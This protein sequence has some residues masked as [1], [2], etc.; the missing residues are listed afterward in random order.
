[1]DNR[2]PYC[3]QI[4]LLLSLWGVALLLALTQPGVAQAQGN[5]FGSSAP[6]G[7][8]G[9]GPGAPMGS[10]PTFAP[11]GPLQGM[12]FILPVPVIRFMLRVAEAQRRFSED[13]SEKMR[14]VGHGGSWRPAAVIVLL[15]F[16]YGIFHAVGPGHGKFVTGTYFMVRRARIVHGVLMG[17]VIAGVQ[18]VVAIVAVLLLAEIVQMSGTHLLMNSVYLEAVSYTLVILIGVAML[19]SS[20][21][22]RHSLFFGHS[23]GEGGDLPPRAGREMLSAAVAAGIRPCSGA[24]LVL[25]FSIAQGV[26]ILGIVATFAM[27]V[28]VAMTVGMLGVSTI[29]LR[30]GVGTALRPSGRVATWTHRAVA[31]LGSLAIIGVGSLLLLGALAR[32][33]MPL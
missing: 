4:P 3:R 25:L 32:V 28:G 26:L 9:P 20:V 10:A 19:V 31:V 2:V 33:G 27:A 29:L 17:A 14:A 6:G 8:R 18:A 21:L 15:A 13:L 24:I 23:H 30:H 7:G 12:H 22:G 11:E 5:P 16:L 1:M